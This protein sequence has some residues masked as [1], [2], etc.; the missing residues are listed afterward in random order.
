MG[1]P[2]TVIAT[3]APT[4]TVFEASDITEATADHYKARVVIFTAGVL[5]GQAAPI[6]AYA[7]VA[8]RGRFTVSPAMTDAPSA[9]DGSPC[10]DAAGLGHRN[11]GGLIDRT[12]H[13]AAARG[14]HH[15]GSG[16]RQDDGGRVTTLDV[17]AGQTAP[18]YIS[19][20]MDG[21]LP[22]NPDGTA[23]TMS[24]MSCEFVVH[25]YGGNALAI[26]G[27][28]TLES[29]AAWLVKYSPAAGDFIVGNWRWRLKVTDSGGKIG[30]FPSAGYDELNVR[31]A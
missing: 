24:G 26:S 4:T 20:K 17:I 9:A 31:A 15:A 18:L 8:G 11:N 28:V 6:T 23:L 1:I 2:G 19:L 7:L 12:H 5:L 13:R 27:A 16:Q 3:V 21:A 10:R 22:T 29:A 25:D 30:Y 14:A